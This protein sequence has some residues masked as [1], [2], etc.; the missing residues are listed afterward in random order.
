LSPVASEAKPE[1]F[2]EKLRD[3]F[4]GLF[5]DT[6]PQYRDNESPWILQFYVQDEFS[7]QYLYNMIEGYIQPTAEGSEFSESYKAMIKEYTEWLAKP[8]GI[9]KD[10]KV[11]GN[12]FYGG[13]RKVRV[14]MYRQ[15]MHKMALRRGR[16]ALA[17]LEQ[18]TTSF[19]AKLKGVGVEAK[20]LNEDDFNQ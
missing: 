14:V 7:M 3:G 4:Q 9:F 12:Q 11:T 16:S 19:I 1:K 18:V 10:Y 17:D 5:Q 2:L 6:F 20:R 15:H 8:E 13:Q